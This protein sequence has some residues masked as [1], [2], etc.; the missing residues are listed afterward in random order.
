MAV[1]HHLAITSQF[2][3]CVSFPD[4]IVAVDVINDFSI[5]HEKPTIDPPFGRFRLFIKFENLFSFENN[6]AEARWG[7]D[8]GYS[9]QF[10]MGIVK[11][12]QGA[13]V[14]IGYAITIGEHKSLVT[15]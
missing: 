3:H 1:T 5:K 4:S 12:H 10:A 2:F 7:T 14:D 13:D 15:L 9:G 6:P 11:L 8:G